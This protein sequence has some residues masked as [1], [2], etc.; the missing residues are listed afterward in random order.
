MSKALIGAFPRDNR[1]ELLFEKTE[2]CQLA[3]EEADISSVFQ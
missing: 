3:D 2:W 1:N